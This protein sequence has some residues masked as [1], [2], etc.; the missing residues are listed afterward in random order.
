MSKLKRPAFVRDGVGVLRLTQG[1]EAIVDIDMLSLVGHRNWYVHTKPKGSYSDQSPYAAT[2]MI[3]GGKSQQ[4]R[5]HI[6]V[7]RQHGIAVPKGMATDHINRNSLDNRFENLRVVTYSENAINCDRG[8][9]TKGVY[10]KKDKFRNSMYEAMICV[11]GKRVYLGY[12][13]TKEE[14]RE[15]YIEAKQLREE[16]KL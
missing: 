7:L 13:C 10:L 1:Y 9:K 12:F 14:A 11:D 4:V 6:E 5:L 8:D 2:R 15:A 3:V 16:G